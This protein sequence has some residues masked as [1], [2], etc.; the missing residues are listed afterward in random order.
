[1]KTKKFRVWDNENNCYFKPIH[2]AHK[3]NLEE[4]H[5]G[6]SGDLCMRTMTNFTHESVFP[7]RFS[8]IE[9]FT[10]LQDKNGKDVY[11]G[12]I[13]IINKHDD[14]WHDDVIY[15]KSN[16]R[17]QLRTFRRNATDISLKDVIKDENESCEV[18]GN[19]HENPELL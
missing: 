19:I 11:E 7:D 3:G 15:D 1:M 8:N 2:E 5:I 14:E 17:F 4:L 12:D 9:Q 18:V 6:M 13:F 10:G 16:A